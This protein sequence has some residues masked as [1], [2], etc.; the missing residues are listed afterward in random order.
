MNIIY[1][2]EGTLTLKLSCFYI[3][4]NH[5]RCLEG[6]S[7]NDTVRWA[8]KSLMFPCVRNCLPDYS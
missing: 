8:S 5:V 2:L 7:V 4:Q 3:K 6:L 1:T